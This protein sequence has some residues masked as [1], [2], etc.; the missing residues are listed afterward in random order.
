MKKGVIIGIILIIVLALVFFL[1]KPS[2]SEDE[3]KVL[4]TVDVYIKS[5][6]GSVEGSNIDFKKAR[7]L[8]AAGYKGDLGNQYAVAQTYCIQDG[9]GKTRIKN[10]ELNGES[11]W[12][13]VKARKT[14][15]D[16][17]QLMWKFKLVKEDISWRI[18]AIECL[19]TP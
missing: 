17:W 5:T 10:Y 1:S 18:K 6:L 16:D 4:N 7:S 11:A 2:F 9:P 19:Q 8:L 3:L 15:K 13:N 14:E 12:V